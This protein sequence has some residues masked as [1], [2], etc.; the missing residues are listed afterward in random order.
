MLKFIPLYLSIVL[1]FATINISAQPYSTRPLNDKIKTLQVRSSANMFGSQAIIE[2]ESS[3]Q[4]HFSFDELS[5]NIRNLYYSVQ[6]CNSNWTPASTSTME[7]ANGFNENPI[8]DAQTSINTHML[9][10]HYRFALPNEELSFKLSG[11]YVV[12]IYDISTPEDVLATFCFSV[13][14]SKV[15]I[16]GSV[17]GNTDTDIRNR[18]QQVDFSV[19]PGKYEIENPDS[20]VKV[21]VSQN[22]RTDNEVFQI[23]PTYISKEK[24]SY[25]NNKAL[26]FEGGNEYEAMDFSSIYS[27]SGNVNKVRFHHPYYH[28]EL[29]PD[30][31]EPYAPYYSQ[32]DVN[33]GF[34]INV[35]EYSDN[36]TE[37]DYFLVHFSIPCENPFFD[38]SIYILGDFNQNLL[39]EN[40]LMSY[41]PNLKCY[42]KTVL[43]KQGGY[44]YQYAF[45]PKKTRKVTF[46][47]IGGSHW[48]T[49]NEYCIFVYHR[50]FGERYDKLVGVRILYS[51]K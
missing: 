20:E 2:L 11:N 13:V 23:S 21:L 44:N 39:N 50:P 41:N 3:A 49:D 24:L 18:M 10:T 30:P 34:V 28:V 40:V 6:H 19:F 38:G 26:I 14:E 22:K 31:I 32:H 36:D 7:W 37:S 9:Y 51:G 15:A 48:Q 43:M 25:V 46:Q 16:T 12:S 45:V 33:G 17:R 8:Y 5:P 42:E 29:L 1:A 35:Q 27:F 4:L 47:K